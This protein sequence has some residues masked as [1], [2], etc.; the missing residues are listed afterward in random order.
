MKWS[1]RFLTGTD[2]Q[3]RA[4]GGGDG[5]ETARGTCTAMKRG[6]GGSRALYAP[7]SVVHSCNRFR[8]TAVV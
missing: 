6:S 2:E 7:W 3:T 8:S 5:S 4:T 1:V